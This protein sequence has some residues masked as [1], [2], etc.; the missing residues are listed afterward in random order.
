MT[1][2]EPKEDMHTHSPHQM[3][4]KE[5][6]IIIDNA[7]PLIKYF[8]MLI[9]MLVR[10]MEINDGWVVYKQAQDIICNTKAYD[11]VIHSLIINYDYAT[12]KHKEQVNEWEDKEESESIQPIVFINLFS[13]LLAMSHNHSKMKRILWKYRHLF[14]LEGLGRRRGYGELYLLDSLLTKQLIEQTD[15]FDELISKL[16]KRK[17]RDNLDVILKILAKLSIAGSCA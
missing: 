12:S 6:K 3:Q 4:N 17:S 10:K 16:L 13:C 11:D 9:D 2:I 1:Q 15:Q 5:I 7:N 8:N 14:V